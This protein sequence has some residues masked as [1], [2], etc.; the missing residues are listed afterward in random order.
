M[1]MNSQGGAPQPGT[2]LEAASRKTAAVRKELQVAGAELHLSNAALER[3]LPQSVK[4]GD[5]AHALAQR[6]TIE[7]KVVEA[8]DE[9]NAVNELLDEEV[10][11]R[12]RLERELAKAQRATKS[13]G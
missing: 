9:L 7:E 11:E 1:D 2:P 4:R 10:A 12:A 6:D 8:A 13:S 3:H 5:V